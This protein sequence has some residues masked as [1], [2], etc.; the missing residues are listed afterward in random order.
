M[1]Y[2]FA[3]GYES[4]SL[5]LL[6]WLTIST[7][8]SK[9]P[10]K[11]AMMGLNVYKFFIYLTMV[12]F[13]IISTACV[14]AIVREAALNSLDVLEKFYKLWNT[15]CGSLSISLFLHASGFLF[16]GYRLTATLNRGKKMQGATTG[17]AKSFVST[18]AR[19]S[20]VAQQGPKPKR[21]G[22]TVTIRNLMVAVVIG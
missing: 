11:Y 3:F 1:C 16:A 2:G 18:V 9:R 22:L 19:E 14:I 12:W 6:K 13:P 20:A 5:M 7:G 15:L 8:G 21:S 4:L 17:G 10:S